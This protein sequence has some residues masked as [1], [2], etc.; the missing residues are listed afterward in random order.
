MATRKPKQDPLDALT[1][2]DPQ[3][4]MALMLWKN[5]MRN[6]DMAV[7]IEEKDIQ[8]FD[9]CVNYLK[10]KPQVRVYRPEGLPAQDAIPASANRRAVPAR[11]ATPPRPYVIVVLT[12]Q[13]GD[14]IRPVENNEEDFAA[15]QDQGRTQR[16]REQAQSLAGQLMN[17]AK[18]GEYSLAVMQECADALV[19][20]SRA[21]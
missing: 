10:V 18:T 20:L 6:P 16:Y 21:G 9:D 17:Q 12:D 8:G 15:A 11:A 19:A 4:V 5:R 2:G 14:V 13:K 7:Q 3:R 1:T